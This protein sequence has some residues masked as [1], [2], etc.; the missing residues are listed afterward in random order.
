[1]FFLLLVAAVFA[2]GYL[3]GS[4]VSGRGP[5]LP[6]AE[7][8]RGMAPGESARLGRI[9]GTVDTMATELERLSE[10]QRFLTKLLAERS[11]EARRDPPPS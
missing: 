2:L 10:G 7:S 11:G 9:E 3:A 8:D 5:R 4:Y 1:M 6:G